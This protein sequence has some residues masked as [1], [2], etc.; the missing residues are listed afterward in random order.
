ML[1]LLELPLGGLQDAVVTEAWLRSA[2]EG[3]RRPVV[4]VAGQ[5][6]AMERV[7][8]DHARSTWK[9]AWQGVRKP[10]MRSWLKA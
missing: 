7:E 6:V 9:N 10:A 1:R 3:A 4:L 5:L 2:A 8:A